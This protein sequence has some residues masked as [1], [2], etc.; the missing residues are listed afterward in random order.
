MALAARAEIR[1]YASG[2]LITEVGD[3]CRELLLLIAGEAE[4]QRPLANGEIQREALRPGQTLDELEVLTHSESQST[5][6][7]LSADT[8]I[9]AIPVDAFD[10]L[11]EADRDFARRVLELESKQL[12]KFIRSI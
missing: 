7:A 6:A 4:I 8:R 12:Q 9:L 3:T 10:D 2:A 1:T 11:L 5:I